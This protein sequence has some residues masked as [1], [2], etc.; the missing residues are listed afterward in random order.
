MSLYSGISQAG[1]QHKKVNSLDR[2]QHISS[3]L[4][5]QELNDFEMSVENCKMKRG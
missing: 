4:C 3:I 1:A 2:K 5:Y